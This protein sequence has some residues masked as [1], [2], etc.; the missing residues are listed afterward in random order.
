MVFALEVDPRD[1]ALREVEASL[2]R[3][4]TDH[5]DYYLL[6]MLMDKAMLARLA[7]PDAPLEERCGALLGL[8]AD[9]D[10]PAVVPRPIPNPVA[11]G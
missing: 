5:V 3:L 1:A 9:A 2:T 6:H 11:A 4:Q 7:D 8:A 10:D